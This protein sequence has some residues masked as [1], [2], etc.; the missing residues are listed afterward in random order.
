MYILSKF[1]IS[2][3]SPLGASL[4]LGLFALL[5]ATFSRRRMAVLSGVIAVGWLGFWSLPLA[6]N[7]LRGTL[8]DQFP[9]VPVAS[10]P[11]AGAI[12]VLGGGVTP[13]AKGRSVPNLESGAD[14]VWYG[15]RLMHAGKAPVVV[16]SG[17]AD[18]AFSA[19]TE[20][21]AMRE[22]M[23]DLGVDNESVF[24]ETRSRNTFENARFSVNI[25]NKVGIDT[26]ILVTS[27]IH[28]QRAL[29]RFKN[30]GIRVIPAATDHEVLRR[31]GWQNWLPDT[32]ALDGSARAMKEWVGYCLGR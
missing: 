11:Q 26:I 9:P 3:I 6:S 7:W 17:G 16:L 12:V 18:L 15:A 10:V 29:A 2:L 31:P 5:F 25:L 20:A 4:L 22:L 21:E 32:A 30:E 19:T 28:M 27:A 1:A 24:L 23:L 14:R 13:P 8:E